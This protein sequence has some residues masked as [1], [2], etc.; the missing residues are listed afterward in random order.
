VS[1]G[2]EVEQTDIS[3][4]VSVLE[5]SEVVSRK[6]FCGYAKRILIDRRV[7]V[8]SGETRKCETWDEPRVD[9]G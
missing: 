2:R 4:R 7:E 6:Q 1:K 5:V 9:F 3:L 8:N